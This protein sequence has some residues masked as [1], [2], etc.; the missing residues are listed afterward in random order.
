MSCRF[1]TADRG[2]AGSMLIW[3]D[4]VTGSGFGLMQS[5]AV[6]AGPSK[7]QAGLTTSQ[8]AIVTRLVT[9]Q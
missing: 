9:I 4:A 6:A 7:S 2:L 3:F 1:Q 5:L 8:H